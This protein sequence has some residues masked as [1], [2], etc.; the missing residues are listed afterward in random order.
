MYGLH[1]S[2]HTISWQCLM[3]PTN[4]QPISSTIDYALAYQ[5]WRC[6]LSEID[7]QA[8]RREHVCKVCYPLI[9]L[10]VLRCVSMCHACSMHH[11]TGAT[12]LRHAIILPPGDQ[13]CK[14]PA[15]TAAP[16]VLHPHWQYVIMIILQRDETNQPA[17]TIHTL[18]GNQ[19][20]P[21]HHGPWIFMS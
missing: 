5:L 1:I 9:Q 16:S 10:H 21:H 11:G 8:W 18:H 17:H 19:H 12:A 13:P 4:N 2:C 14:H 3:I 7:K 15:H 6:S 20:A